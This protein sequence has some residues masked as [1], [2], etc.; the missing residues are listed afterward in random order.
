MEEEIKTEIEEKVIEEKP[1][2]KKVAKKKENKEPQL[3]DLPGVGPGTVAKLEEAG[4]CD[5]M[6][7]AALSPAQ[8]SEK[9]GMS[10][11]VARKVIQAAYK[12]TDMG[13][14]TGT[15]QKEKDLSLKYVSFG[16]KNLD[17]LLGGKGIRSGAITIG[18]AHV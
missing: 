17:N 2:K 18:R 6:S 15:K 4:V 10:E 11:A 16:C 5:I 1:K 7:V 13:F 9:S 8:L 3:S 14:H 12:L